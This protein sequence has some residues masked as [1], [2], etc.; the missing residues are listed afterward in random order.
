M[1]GCVNMCA[2]YYHIPFPFCFELLAH[3]QS[4]P[5]RCFL[6]RML[7]VR[8]LFLSLHRQRHN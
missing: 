6:H 8:G 2:Y 3:T 1:G 5:N 7:R 4:A